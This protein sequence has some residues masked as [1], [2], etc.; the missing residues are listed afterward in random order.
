MPVEVLYVV[1]ALVMQ[2]RRGEQRL[3]MK[4]LNIKKL[5]IYAYYSVLKSLIAL[6]DVSIIIIAVK[7]DPMLFLLQMLTFIIF[8]TWSSKA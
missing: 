7:K 4:H 3:K 1:S 2:N 8:K 5:C 6:P